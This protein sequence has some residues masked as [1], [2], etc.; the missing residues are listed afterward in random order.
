MNILRIF[1]N[2]LFLNGP[3]W[4]MEKYLVNIS[5]VGNKNIW[6]RNQTFNPVHLIW[7]LKK[8]MS[9]SVCYTGT[10]RTRTSEMKWQVCL[11]SSHTSYN[12]A[13]VAANEN[14][15]TSTFEPSRTKRVSMFDV[16]STSNLEHQCQKHRHLKQ[17]PR[18]FRC[19]RCRG[20]ITKSK[21]CQSCKNISEYCF[22][23]S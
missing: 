7:N 23:S 22:C 11:S 21:P 4:K 13:A 8:L 12:V 10:Y 19:F 1:Q 14:L 9:M 20:S 5:T 16:T 15:K 2:I 18:Y 3:H 17:K 6:T